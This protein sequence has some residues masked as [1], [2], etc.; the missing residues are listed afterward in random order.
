MVPC[1]P[2]SCCNLCRIATSKKGVRD[3]SVT[4]KGMKWS[5]S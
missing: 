1:Q 3:G 5:K 2:F 4:E